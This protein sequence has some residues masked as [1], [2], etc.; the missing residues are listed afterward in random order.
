MRKFVLIALLALATPA[1]AQQLTG[2]GA[3]GPASGDLSGFYP[4]PT[5][6]QYQGNAMI[7]GASS[8]TVSAIGGAASHS[9]APSDTVTL[10][11]GTGT[12]N[13]VLAVTDTQLSAVA[14]ITAAGSGCTNGSG[15]ILTGTTG[16]GTKFQ[17]SVTVSGNAVAS[18]DSISVA[19]DYTVNPTSLTAEPVTGDSCTGVQLSVIMGAKA[20]S[21][22]TS[23]LYSVLPS[24]PV[25]Q[26]SSSGSGTGA[27]WT[28]SWAPAPCSL[29]FT[30]SVSYTPTDASGATLTFSGVSARY[31]RACGWV[32]GFFSVTYPSTANGSTATVSLPV[33]SANVGSRVGFGTC[34]NTVSTFSAILVVTANS[35]NAGLVNPATNANIT[36]ANMTNNQVECT[37]GYPTQ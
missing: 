7:L 8:A 6:S 3:N 31:Q 29:V 17:V 10:T 24:N 2:G 34:K 15:K 36:N 32:N 5:V 21:I 37:F 16:T 20:A 11:G 27:T 33:T 9:Y 30:P 19:G 22:S 28:L 4:N 26:G 18:V 25:A 13:A 1:A 23:G 12:A 14:S 35:T